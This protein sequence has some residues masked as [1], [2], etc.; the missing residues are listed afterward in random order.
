MYSSS[1]YCTVAELGWPMYWSY[2]KACIYNYTKMYKCAVLYIT[3]S[4]DVGILLHVALEGTRD[5]EIGTQVQS[6]S[7]I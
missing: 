5:K 6:S 3:L 7:L 2:L 1:V 4:S